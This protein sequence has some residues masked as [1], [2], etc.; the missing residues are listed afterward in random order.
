MDNKNK[1]NIYTVSIIVA[2]DAHNCG[3]GYEGTLPWKVSSDMKFFKETTSKSITNKKMNVLICGRNTFESFNNR[4]LPNRHCIVLTHDIRKKF[5]DYLKN[6][7]PT[8]YKSGSS[9]KFKESVNTDTNILN[10]TTPTGE[11]LIFLND[12]NSLSQAL[13]CIKNKDKIFV[14]GGGAVYK[15][16]LNGIPNIEL[17]DCIITFIGKNSRAFV[18]VFANKN[19]RKYDI[20][21]PFYKVEEDFELIRTKKL[22]EEIYIRVFR[23]KGKIKLLIESLLNYFKYCEFYDDKRHK[24]VY[25]T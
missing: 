8:G 3:I 18:G 9:Y 20:Y 12:I 16:F 15:E 7:N 6:N 25:L 21:F 11:S 13:D 19:G 24:T 23:K 5:D 14:V 22:E 4:P 10:I 1:R 17:K 2:M